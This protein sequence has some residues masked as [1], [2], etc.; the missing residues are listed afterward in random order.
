MENTLI[1]ATVA[2]STTPTA[3]QHHFSL[4]QVLAT[5]LLGSVDAIAAYTDPKNIPSAVSDFVK[6]FLGIWTGQTPAQ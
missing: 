3:P 4:G 5:V 1:P 6:G 2:A